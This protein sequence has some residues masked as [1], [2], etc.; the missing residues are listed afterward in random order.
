MMTSIEQSSRQM[1]QII[2]T[3]E[4]IAFQTNIHNSTQPWKPRAQA[5][6]KGFA[7]VAG[8]VARVAQKQCGCSA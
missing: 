5:R 2:S 4:G 7:V 6:G 3:I 1:G 8:E